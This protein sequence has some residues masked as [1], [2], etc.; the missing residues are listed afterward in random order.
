MLTEHRITTRGPGS[1][2]LSRFHFTVASLCKVNEVP[3][4]FFP[5]LA[6]LVF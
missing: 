6:T 5:S 1:R 2:H 3:T 4:R